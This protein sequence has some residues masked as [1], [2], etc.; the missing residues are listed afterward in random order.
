MSNRD[1]NSSNKLV[2]TNLQKK[3]YKR[4]TKLEMVL[5]V[6][7]YLFKVLEYLSPKIAGWWGSRLWL[8]T[9]RF[10]EPSREKHW[11]ESAQV[12]ELPHQYG[13]ITLY[14]WHKKQINAP[15]VL[16]IHGW[17]GRGLQLAAFVKPLI[18]QGFQVIS[19][20][21]PG[22]G[23]SP[24]KESN[25][26]RIADVV[27]S[28]SNSIGAIDCIIGH[29]FG[30]MVMAKVVKDG[31]DIRKAVA[32]SSPMNAD[33]LFNEFCKILN[34]K[35]RSKE[36]LL[37]RV[38]SRF[39]NDIF[40]QISALNN[41]RQLSIPGLIIHDTT[42]HDIPLSH[43]RELHQAWTGSDLLITENL[44]HLRILRNNAVINA[45]TDYI[46]KN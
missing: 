6:M 35:G 44:G 16:L 38:Y 30:A 19:F 5:K 7:A 20:D 11:L 22:H 29:S 17:N 36:N 9:R 34:I 28:I 14:Q 23:R 2:N 41:V 32:I 46:S 33:Y 45:V 43:A 39:D 27:H 8:A 15:R 24:G 10:P 4:K 18:S 21:A 26:L 13:P 25:L 31:L 37:H 12:S 40:L 1:T 3:S 42:D